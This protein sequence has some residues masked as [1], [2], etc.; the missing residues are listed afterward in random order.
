MKK[1]LLIPA[2]VL[3]SSAAFANS[4]SH[5]APSVSVGHSFNTTNT[6]KAT[7]NQAMNGANTSSGKHSAAGGNTQIG[8]IT[9]QS[10]IGGF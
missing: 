3:V 4:W 9:Q 2:F 7:I 1:L 8:V 10:P 5:S 6:N